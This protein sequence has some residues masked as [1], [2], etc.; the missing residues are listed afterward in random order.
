MG[1]DGTSAAASVLQVAELG[2]SLAKSIHNFVKTAKNAD[3]EPKTVAADTRLVAVALNRTH[4]E[5]WTR[6]ALKQPTVNLDFEGV[7]QGT[8]NAFDEVG[9]FSALLFKSHKLKLLG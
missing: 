2:F 8:G 9:G 6:S 3:T 7:L 5:I 4:H 1:L